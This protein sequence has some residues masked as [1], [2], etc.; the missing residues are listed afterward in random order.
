MQPWNAVV[1]VQTRFS[2]VKEPLYQPLAVAVI[3]VGPLPSP[4]VPLTIPSLI[5]STLCHALAKGLLRVLV[6]KHT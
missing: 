3:G 1:V 4:R 6:S 5:L 2:R